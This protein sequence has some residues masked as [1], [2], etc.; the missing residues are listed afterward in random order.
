MR[1]IE[2]AVSAILRASVAALLVLPTVVCAQ[3]AHAP[4]FLR[5]PVV[6]V[7]LAPPALDDSDS[8]AATGAGRHCV[9][10]DRIVGA[11]VLGDRTIELVLENGER[12]HIR[13]AQQCPFIGFYQGFYYRHPQA[14]QLCAGRDSVIDRSGS[15]CA[16][17]DIRRHKGKRP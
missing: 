12:F 8:P 5:P 10:A 7:P 6:R 17:E 9:A 14:G 4:R 1:V 11:T 2:G 16:I 3:A 15:A 13:F